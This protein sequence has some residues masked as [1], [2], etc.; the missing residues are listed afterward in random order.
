MV[1]DYLVGDTPVLETPQSAP[2][3]V[4]NGRV[5]PVLVRSLSLGSRSRPLVVRLAAAPAAAAIVG[6][7]AADRSGAR[8]ESRDGYLDLLIPAGEELLDDYGLYEYPPW[9]DALCAEFGVDRSFVDR[10]AAPAK[11][12]WKGY[13]AGGVAAAAK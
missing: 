7:A 13:E 8:I 12:T 9:Y 2:P 1:L 4:E 5:V 11:E 10:K 6:P 3:L